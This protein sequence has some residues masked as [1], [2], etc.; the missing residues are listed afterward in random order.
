[1]RISQPILA[2]LAVVALAPSAPAGDHVKLGVQ[3]VVGSSVAFIPYEKGYFAAEGL[4]VEL[5]Y[6]Q[7]QEPIVVGAASGGIDYGMT[8]FTGGFYNLAGQGALRLIAAY[9][10]EAAG[11]QGQTLVAS[12]RAFDAGMKTMKNLPGHT[13]AVAEI[14]GPG[15]YGLALIADKFGFDAKTVRIL[16]MGTNPNAVS[17]VTGGQADVAFLPISFARPGLQH[18][19]TK[20]IG[21]L[22]DEVPW[23]LGGV[24]TS[25]K[26]ANERQ[27]QVERFLRAYKKGVQEFHDAF[28]GPGEIRQDGETTDGVVAIA[29]K[30]T[31][32]PPEQVKQ[33]ISY[34]DRDARLD[35]K[36]ILHQ[37][38]WYR[39]QGM[40]KGDFDPASVIDRRY[41]VPLP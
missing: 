37:I 16:S 2:L 31:G 15:H 34:F 30:Y 21:W 1:M 41:V 39:S 18:G 25:T 3:K 4:D 40:V 38:A 13:A 23:Q 29:S 35:V 11:F 36:D 33:G 5:V 28:T 19:D 22:G 17:A 7:A 8:A 27:D 14:G 6:F 26:I 12:P 20:L 24:F 9:I 32:L 10:H